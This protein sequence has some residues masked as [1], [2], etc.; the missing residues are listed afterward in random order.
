[1]S[2][3]FFIPAL[4]VCVGVFL[5]A[6]RLPMGSMTVRSGGPA[7]M[8]NSNMPNGV[9][10][11]TT[12]SPWT[13][14]FTNTGGTV[15]YLFVS[16][17]GITAPTMTATYAGTSLTQL[18][19]ES[20]TNA[21]TIFLFRL[22][23]PATGANNFVIT[24]NTGAQTTIADAISFTGNAAVPD[25]GSAAINAW[26]GS[27][28]TTFPLTVSG[29]TGPATGN[30]VLQGVCYGDATAIPNT[31][32]TSTGTIDSQ[33]EVN[34]SSVCNNLTV[35]FQNSAA[36]TTTP[37][38]GPN[39]T[40]TSF[41]T[42][43]IEVRSAS[44]PN[45]IQPLTNTCVGNQNGVTSSSVSCTWGVAPPA[46]S[47]LVCGGAT[48]S[49]GT[50]TITALTISDGTT[51]T[52][53]NAGGSSIFNV[54]GQNYLIIAYRLNIGVTA[55]ATVT[56][57]I[58]GATD[59]FAN[60]VCYAMRDF[61]GGPVPDGTCSF[62]T[63]STVSTTAQC[64]TAINTTDTD[65]VF[66]MCGI[67]GTPVQRDSVAHWVTAS[68]SRGAVQQFVLQTNQGAANPTYVNQ[69]G[70]TAGILGFALKP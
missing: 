68:F 46:G 7:L 36:S 57:T 30:L 65:M 10:V 38:I 64:T 31:Q 52:S 47:S 12:A 2:R 62:G 40:A 27:A 66:G 19:S 18:G 15:L 17:D 61:V 1:M 3:L 67:S 54:T 8:I 48:F 41:K 21:G 13:W 25:S 43:G 28:V 58:T 6:Q 32:T 5:P 45:V 22:T 9:A 50:G 49:G 69:G 23:L 24:W 51:F 11:T 59:R 42:I 35:Q 37:T 26:T 53:S 44:A 56:M 60:I 4:L 33:L 14:S 20:M 70:Q 16:I 55:P 34:G 63:N 29:T 39:S